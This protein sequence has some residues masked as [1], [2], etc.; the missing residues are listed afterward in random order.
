MSSLCPGSSAAV[1][2]LVIATVSIFAPA[3]GAAT[4]WDF[5]GDGRADL[6]I[7]DTQDPHQG[8]A[9]V[10]YGAPR[11]LTG[12]HAQSFTED[13][14]GVAGSGFPHDEFGWSFAAGDFDG[15]GYDDLAVGAPYDSNEAAGA[16][17]VQ[18][19]GA[20]VTLYGSAAG[21][22]PARSQVWSQDSAGIPGIAEAGDLFGWSVASGDFN[23][24]GFA[25]LAVGAPLEDLRNGYDQ[26]AVDVIYGSPAGLSAA[27]SVMETQ[28]PGLAD[29]PENDDNFGFA[30]A[31][32]NLGRGPA[33]DLAV[34][35]P[36]EDLGAAH[37]AGAVNVLMGSPSGLGTAHD[38]L[39]DQRGDD[40]AGRAQPGDAF[41]FSLAT[42]NFG[43][44]PATD[45]AVGV[46]GEALGG[47]RYAGGVEVAYGGSD[48]P[49][50]NGSQLLSQQTPG[51]HGRVA[52]ED[53]FGMAVAAADF[54]HGSQD[55]LAAGV[56]ND[57]GR[58]GPAGAGAVNVVFGSPAGLRATGNQRLS[59]KPNGI[60]GRPGAGDAFGAAL[61]AANFG[62]GARDDLAVGV[63]RE[64]VSGEADAGAVA[65]LYGSRVGITGA[66]NQLW[67]EASAGV[68]GAPAAFELFGA[69]LPG[70]PFTLLSL[71]CPCHD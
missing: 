38:R 32:A 1:T 8:A 20:V 37:E 12:T 30:L 6:A 50:A 10:L 23:H 19:S 22:A 4:G 24:D 60:L 67:S 47:V 33:A 48:R 15:D 62:G 21:L 11:G 31:T 34:G 39:L 43:I 49:A 55:D 9:V 40:T 16:A 42:G 44:G 56:P 63:P 57:S 7:G 17:W 46:P 70:S 13:T 29:Q 68:P 27:G 28:G 3:A 2:L 61:S 53:S 58:R 64:D 14:P 25:D 35:A 45:L 54:G 51:I 69:A 18:Y 52:L 5:N 71:H 65:A 36:F 66:G 59:Q 26:G 41:G